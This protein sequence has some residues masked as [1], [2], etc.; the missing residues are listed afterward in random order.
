MKTERAAV[1]STAE[2]LPV[3]GHNEEKSKEAQR[4]EAQRKRDA[5]MG[6]THTEL[7]LSTTERALLDEARELRGGYSVVEYLA[8]L[9]RQDHAKAK[10][11]LRKIER[12]SCARCGLALPAGCL[13]ISDTDGKGEH[14]GFEHCWRTRNALRLHL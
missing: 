11:T 13:A 7:R 9:I 1:P 6:I 5:A 12:E 10:A 4:K 14:E 3:T 8:T 2:A